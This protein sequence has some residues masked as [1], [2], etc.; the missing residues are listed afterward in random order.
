MITIP[1]QSLVPMT[2]K[3]FDQAAWMKSGPPCDRLDDVCEE[4]FNF[5]FLTRERSGYL[6]N[7]ISERDQRVSDRL[8]T[9]AV[10]LRF[11]K[12]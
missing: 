7:P 9:V 10:D 1:N 2:Q 6:V 8:D 3:E 11:A 4:L 12:T 5:T